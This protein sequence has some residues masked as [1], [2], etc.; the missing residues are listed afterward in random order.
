MNVK[1]F[2]KILLDLNKTNSSK[3][4]EEILRKRVLQTTEWKYS[5]ILL[6]G[7]E[8]D[9]AGI[10]PKSVYKSLYKAYPNYKS[11][12][13]WEQLHQENGSVTDAILSVEDEFDE[14]EH[15]EA[16]V[17]NV[18]DSLK[19][20]A[21]D[22][23]NS[24]INK[25]A[26][27]FKMYDSFVVS[28]GILNDYN[29]G[30]T[31]KSIKNSI[32]KPEF[33]KQKLQRT[34][35]LVPDAIEYILLFKADSLPSGPEPGSVFKPMAAKSKDVPEN[36]SDYVSQYKIDGYR[37]LIH[38]ENNMV[39]GITRNL[40]NETNSL[41]ELQEID[42]PDGGYIFDCEAIAYNKKGESL[43]FK[44]TSER[45]GRKHGVLT[46]DKTIHFKV[47]D[48]LYNKDTDISNEPFK[49]RF[50]QLQ[51]VIPEHE[52]IE[53]IPIFEN[54]S[55]SLQ[56]AEENNYE[57]VIVKN[58]NAPYMFGK[59]SKYWR[60]IKITEETIDL[61][62]RGFEQEFN[63]NGEKTLGA[64]ELETKD[65][66]FVGNV[67]TGFTDKQKKEIWDNQEK[68][69][70]S[71]VEIQFEGFDDKLRF[72]SFKSFRP[73]GEADSLQRIKNIIN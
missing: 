4:K 14:T 49:N 8:F 27:T 42:W 45:I 66:V 24:A 33:S 59:R 47:F 1:T 39:K 6:A 63:T 30:V 22:S 41:P 35:G 37:L 73:D 5:I 28:F 58:K 15:K 68:Y 64:L 26:Q 65:G 7:Q 9:N 52:Y 53:V 51:N 16:S 69:Y 55:K 3:K 72:P 31:E 48:L 56:L 54:I 34:R 32:A 19:R 71:V 29:I 40:N 43:G 61:K 62:I 2:R 44:E 57:G 21:E 12:S 46:D 10:A 17:K 60:K 25:L 70:D 13:E 67:G 20:V 18:Y 11:V 38:V 50:K 36:D 23:G